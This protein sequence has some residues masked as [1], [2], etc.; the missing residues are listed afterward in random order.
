MAVGVGSR[1][2]ESP[3]LIPKALDTERLLLPAK[4][5]IPTRIRKT[6]R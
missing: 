4:M 2:D 5:K 3:S 6:R 1:G